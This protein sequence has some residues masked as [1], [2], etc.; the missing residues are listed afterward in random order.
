MNAYLYKSNVPTTV[1][2]VDND[3]KNY[4]STAMTQLIADGFTIRNFFHVDGTLF[5]N[6]QNGIC[7]GLTD[8]EPCT[9]MTWLDY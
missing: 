7:S 8:N 3:C 1:S 4:M 2:A 6:W 9:T 5:Y